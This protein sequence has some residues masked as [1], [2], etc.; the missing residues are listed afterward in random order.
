LPARGASGSNAGN[1]RKVMRRQ[2]LA[3]VVGNDCLAL[4]HDWSR[5]AGSGFVG[6]RVG[7]PYAEG[8]AN[9]G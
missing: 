4:I 5:M 6:L 9:G 2:L 3:G 7:V 8:A 1:R